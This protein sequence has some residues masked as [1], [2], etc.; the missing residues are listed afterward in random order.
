ML[1]FLQRRRAD[2]EL[3]P[4]FDAFRNG[5]VHPFGINLAHDRVLLLVHVLTPN[6]DA[7]SAPHRGRE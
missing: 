3:T 4:L 6:R 1:R 7:N 2:F 5:R